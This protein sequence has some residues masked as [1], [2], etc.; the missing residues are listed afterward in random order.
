M[1]V[2]G[3]EVGEGEEGL[4]CG[5]K[6]ASAAATG[7]RSLRGREEGYEGWD[8]GRSREAGEGESGINAD[9]Q[10]GEGVGGDMAGGSGEGVSR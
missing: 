1:G 4:K 5:Q 10:F 3:R 2:V 8:G 9:E 6:V 7:S